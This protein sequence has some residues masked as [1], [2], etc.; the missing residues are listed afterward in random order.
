MELIELEKTD[1]PC[2]AEI[3][4][5]SAKDLQDAT[6][7]VVPVKTRCALNEEGEATTAVKE[8]FKP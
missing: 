2:I 5:G 1:D 7:G 8:P 4:R 6:A 3:A